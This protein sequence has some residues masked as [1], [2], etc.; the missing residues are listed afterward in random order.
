[1]NHIQKKINMDCKM[2][3]FITSRAS[4]GEEGRGQRNTTEQPKFKKNILLY[5]HICLKKLIHCCRYTVLEALCLNFETNCPWVGSSGPWASHIYFSEKNQMPR[6]DI[7]V[8]L[9]QKC[10]NN[11]P[12][13]GEFMLW[14][15]V[16]MVMQWKC[17]KSIKMLS[18]YTAGK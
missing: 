10:R 2:Y 11:W 16:S 7:H 17:I 4:C 6:Y 15:D 14:G 5:S 3:C 12:P 9:D 18:K 13:C 1:M 8:G